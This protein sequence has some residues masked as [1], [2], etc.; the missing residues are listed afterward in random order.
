MADKYISQLPLNNSIAVTDHIIVDDSINTTR[1]TV[2]SLSSIFATRASAYQTLTSASVE[3]FIL[4]Y[5]NNPSL[6][7]VEFK[8]TLNDLTVLLESLLSPS[9]M[10]VENYIVESGAIFSETSQDNNSVYYIADYVTNFYTLFNGHSAHFTT[11]FSSSSYSDNYLTIELSPALSADKLTIYVNEVAYILDTE[12]NSLFSYY[13]Q[14]TGSGWTTCG[15]PGAGGGGYPRSRDRENPPVCPPVRLKKIKEVATNVIKGI[16]ID[17]YNKLAREI[18][19]FAPYNTT[20]KGDLLDLI[21]DAALG[22]LPDGV[23]LAQLISRNVL[24][25]L[26]GVGLANLP[27]R[28]LLEQ[29]TGGLS[30]Q[31]FTAAVNLYISH[32]GDFE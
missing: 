20:L 26:Q 28:A 18:N 14:T 11:N 10:L 17:I 29:K 6:S 30:E 22:D 25:A 32:S 4:M 16:A 23:D 2:G 24:R 8:L 15:K 13:F 5:G 31:I 9:N 3:D 21:T 1:A 7:G 12:T 27:D 19:A